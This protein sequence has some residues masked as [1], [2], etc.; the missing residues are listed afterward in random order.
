MDGKGLFTFVVQHG[1][2]R[3]ESNAFV[4]A[5]F[6]VWMVDHEMTA[7]GAA[8]VHLIEDLPVVGAVFLFHVRRRLTFEQGNIGVEAG[9]TFNLDRLYLVFQSVWTYPEHD[10]AIWRTAKPGTWHYDQLLHDDEFQSLF[11]AELSNRIRFMQ[12]AVQHRRR[13]NLVPAGLA[14]QFLPH[15]PANVVD[16]SFGQ[17]CWIRQLMNFRTGELRQPGHEPRF[18]LCLNR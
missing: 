17:T 13:A 12:M 15:L 10:Q 7:L 1:I 9:G 16:R 11:Y 5:C 18:T 14:S 4:V 6:E 3:I 8:N 2:E